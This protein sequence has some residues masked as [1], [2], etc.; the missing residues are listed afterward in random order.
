MCF[1]RGCREP[2]IYWVTYK[3][4]GRRMVCNGHGFCCQCGRNNRNVL[5]FYE[6]NENLYCWSCDPLYPRCYANY[7]PS[8]NLE[9][10]LR[11][12]FVSNL[13][14]SNVTF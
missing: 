2:A 9:D 13:N 4:S 3:K 14:D 5:R 11:D 6:Y 8:S 10:Y 7:D 1:V 12:S